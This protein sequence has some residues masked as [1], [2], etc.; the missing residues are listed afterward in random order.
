MLLPSIIK[1]QKGLLQHIWLKISRVNLKW[2]G[3]LYFHQSR[4]TSYPRKLLGWL[5]LSAHN[6]KETENVCV[7]IL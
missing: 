1:S 5:K 7:H 3:K 2:G 6:F 4:R